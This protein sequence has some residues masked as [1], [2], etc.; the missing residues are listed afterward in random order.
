VLSGCA[1]AQ[2]TGTPAPLIL[3]LGHVVALKVAL[4]ADMSRYLRDVKALQE[5]GHPVAATGC[6]LVPLMSRCTRLVKLLQALG[7]VPGT[8]NTHGV[9]RSPLVMAAVA[10][11][12]QT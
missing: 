7:R 6:Q 9:S 2:S 4:G 5:G 11:S 10:T 3:L 8:Y 1:A 12:K